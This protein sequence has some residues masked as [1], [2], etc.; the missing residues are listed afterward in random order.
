MCKGDCVCKMM[1]YDGMNINDSD[2]A[3]S[4]SEKAKSAML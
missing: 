3:V 2:E 4:P 1:S